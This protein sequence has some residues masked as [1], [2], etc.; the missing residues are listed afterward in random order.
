MGAGGVG[1]GGVGAGADLRAAV[2]HAGDGLRAADP[3]ELGGQRRPQ[4]NCALDRTLNNR[5]YYA[6]D[7]TCARGSGVN[8]NWAVRLSE[9]GSSESSDLS[10][11]KTIDCRRLPGPYGRPTTV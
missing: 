10:K 5:G 2:E 4:L 3:A 1:A 6:R 8:W 7:H 11:R 9:R